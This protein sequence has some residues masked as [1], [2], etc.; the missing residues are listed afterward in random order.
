MSKTKSSSCET[1][2]IEKAAERLGISRGGAYLAAGRGDLPTIRV[3]K[4]LLV[5]TR[6]LDRTLGIEAQTAA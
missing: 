4:R 5:P 3:G 6:W 1:T 2:T